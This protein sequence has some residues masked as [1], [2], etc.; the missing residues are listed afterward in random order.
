[1]KILKPHSFSGRCR[2][3]PLIS[4]RNQE[5]PPWLLLSSLCFV[6]PDALS[7]PSPK[8]PTGSLLHCQDV[9][10]WEEWLGGDDSQCGS[11]ESGK[12]RRNTAL[13]CWNSGSYTEEHG[14]PSEHQE[15]NPLWKKA[16]PKGV[17]MCLCLRA[18]IAEHHI[19]HIFIF[20]NLR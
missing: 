13:K 10:E 4:Y 12:H 17:R 15:R 9:T 8:F 20:L 6:F 1:M 19:F 3:F 11:W 14:K 18:R 5:H 16:F 2:N 7:Q